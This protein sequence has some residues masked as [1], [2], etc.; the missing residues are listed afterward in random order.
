MLHLFVY[1]INRLSK[2]STVI[3][4]GL[5]NQSWTIAYSDVNPISFY[6]TRTTYDL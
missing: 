5:F 4:I 1:V 2:R 6:I 3:Y